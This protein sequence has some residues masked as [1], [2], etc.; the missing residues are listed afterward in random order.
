MLFLLVCKLFCVCFISN[1]CKISML[2]FCVVCAISSLKIIS[3]K[4]MDL[5][6]LLV[7]DLSCKPNI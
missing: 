5:V 6:Y 2:C 4:N 1:A 7:R 3:L